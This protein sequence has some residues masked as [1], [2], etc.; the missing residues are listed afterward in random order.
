[1]GVVSSLVLSITA[2]FEGSGRATRR[3][4]ADRQPFGVGHQ[5]AAKDELEP[6]RVEPADAQR[7]RER[8]L[9]GDEP[10]RSPAEPHVQAAGEA[11]RIDI[12][13]DALLARG[14]TAAVP[15]IVLI[16]HFKDATSDYLMN[17]PGWQLASVERISAVDAWALRAKVHGAVMVTARSFAVDGKRRPFA[18]LGFASLNRRE[19]V[20]GVRRLAAARRE[21]D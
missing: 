19:L 13:V 4:V 1:M 15:S 12:C 9:D 7:E 8:M 10:R 5:R 21:L 14:G 6:H 3:S 17:F 20:E 18:R 16:G 2:P 11:P